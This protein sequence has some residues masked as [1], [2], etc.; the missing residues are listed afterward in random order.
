MRRYGVHV[1]FSENL[2]TPAMYFEQHNAVALR[3]TGP[4]TD[5][6]IS[7]A[8]EM[9]HSEKK[10]MGTSASAR[11]RQLPRDEYL[12]AELH[13]EAEANARE[14]SAYRGF[15]RVDPATKSPWG[16]GAAALAAYK[17]EVLHARAVRKRNAP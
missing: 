10:E 14:A 17:Q 13:E 11:M 9:L 8:H 5:Y 7:F 12:A 2:A 16:G 15:R 4:A 6:A 1:V 3:S